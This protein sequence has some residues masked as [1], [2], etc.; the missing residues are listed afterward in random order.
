MYNSKS[1]VN[2][3]L[4][5]F[6]VKNYIETLLLGSIFIFKVPRKLNYISNTLKWDGKANALLLHIFEFEVFKYMHHLSH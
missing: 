6:E 2:C 5:V 3:N 4:I 1:I